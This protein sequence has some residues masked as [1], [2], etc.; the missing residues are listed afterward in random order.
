MRKINKNLTNPPRN[1][2]P[3][4]A[5]Y[6]SAILNLSTSKRWPAK[7]SSIYR[8]NIV[9]T[10]LDNYYH[11]K[12][13]YCNQKPKG[14]RLQVEHFR[15]K[16]G[17]KGTAHTGYYWLGYEWTNLLFACGNCN[18][19]KGTEFPLLNGV[20]RL[21]SPI[22]IG[23]NIDLNHNYSYSS[24]IKIEKPVLINPE[25]DNP[26]DHLVYL[27]DGK[28]EHLSDKG[29]ESIRVYDLN[30]DELYVNG[31]QKFIDEFLKKITKRVER[32]SNGQRSFEVAKQDVEDVI[33]ENIL[34]PIAEED[35]FDHWRYKI[36]TQYT[37]YVLY[38]FTIQSQINVLNHAFKKLNQLI[39]P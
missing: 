36:F 3:G 30:R 38:R 17:V 2:K 24:T 33:Y 15:P 20:R 5:A 25:L 29:E 18:G 6:D 39:Q 27:R 14:S 12:C 21:D 34:Q 11:E 32:Y 22:W 16:D 28:L 10:A 7:S 26:D 35:S 8:S 13:A 1:L 23:Q 9:K 4:W 37:D 31:R 19:H